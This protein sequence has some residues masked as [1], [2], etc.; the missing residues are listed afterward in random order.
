[1]ASEHDDQLRTAAR[2]AYERGRLTSSLARALPV[3]FLALLSLTDSHEV[4]LTLVVAAVAF[5]AMVLL[6]FRGGA[7]GLGARWG[8]VAGLVPFAAS[9][10]GRPL[11][12]FMVGGQHVHGC[13]MAC[14][15]ACVAM[16]LLLARVTRR[17]RQPTTAWLAGTFV[18]VLVASTACACV[19]VTGVAVL[20]AGVVVATVP[21]AAIERR[22]ATT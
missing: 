20:V 19:G 10:L 1:M 21:V 4:A 15:A 5:I 2:G 14:G 8:L 9:V 11:P 12:H 18:M 7:L 22:W 13:V 16:T 17:H 6:E 3:P